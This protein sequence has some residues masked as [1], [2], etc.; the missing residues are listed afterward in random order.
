[1]KQNLAKAVIK[2]VTKAF[3]VYRSAHLS[4]TAVKIQRLGALLFISGSL[5]INKN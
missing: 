5:K 4:E 3:K 2:M 1:M